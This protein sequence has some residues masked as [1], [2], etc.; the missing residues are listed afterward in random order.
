MKDIYYW[1]TKY[2]K[3]GMEVHRNNEKE[4]KCESRC[5]ECEYSRRRWVEE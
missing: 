2:S 1:C 3:W 4:E 5:K